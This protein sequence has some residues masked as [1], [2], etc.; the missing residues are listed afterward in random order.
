MSADD[1]SRGVWV[2]VEEDGTVMLPAPVLDAAPL[3]PGDVV[4]VRAVNGVV[5][6]LTH[7][8]VAVEIKGLIDRGVDPNP[9]LDAMPGVDGLIVERRL[10][11]LKEQQELSTR[12]DAAE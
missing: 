11:S 2:K 12:H 4:M 1:F 6:I 5:Q 9:L 3:I 10:E 7:M 8:A